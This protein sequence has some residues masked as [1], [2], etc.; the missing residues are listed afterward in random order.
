M[1][2]KG[3]VD[4]A[5]GINLIVSSGQESTVDMTSRRWC[6]RERRSQRI[7]S[8]PHRWIC[9]GS[10]EEECLSETGVQT[11]LLFRKP[12][13]EKRVRRAQ[14]PKGGEAID[15]KRRLRPEGG[16]GQACCPEE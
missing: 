2:T 5:A 10:I 11:V 3:S 7:C 9:C 16:R 15:M 1:I 13:F 12:K 4:K 8:Q 14:P 6:G